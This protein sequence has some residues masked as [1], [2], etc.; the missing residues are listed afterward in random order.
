MHAQE[1]K[2][3]G[4]V[5]DQTD[6]QRLTRVYIYNTRTNTGFY[7]TTKG[8]FTTIAQP[9]DTLV[10]AL[11][12]YGVDTLSI[13]S[14]N[15][16]L[17]YLKRTSIQIQE[18]PVTDS[19]LSP[20]DKLAENKKTYGDIYRKGNTKDIFTTGGSNN[21]G[22]AGLSITTLYNLLS[23]EGRNARFLQKIIERDYREA[24]ISYRYTAS[25]V[26]QTTGLA[27]DKLEDFMLQYRPAYNFVIEA[28]DYELIRFIKGS[29]QTYLKNPDA[30]RLPP[31]KD[32]GK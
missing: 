19:L 27:G 14:Q 13:R 10:A 2:V 3:Q 18:V 8:E 16:V 1:K 28:N 31:L 7:N 17:F 5:F 32:P 23:R 29:Y 20:A 25:L 6:K 12:G 15:T 24:M 22:G 26:S 21:A 30:N 4:I 9:G 11:Q